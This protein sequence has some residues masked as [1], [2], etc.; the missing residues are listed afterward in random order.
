MTGEQAFPPPARLA[1]SPLV[2]GVP[3]FAKIASASR[4]CRRLNID[5]AP[6]TTKSL[7]RPRQLKPF[8]R[9]DVF[10][11]SPLSLRR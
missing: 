3:L 8:I 7:R 2:V 9:C 10:L 6:Q 1:S 5:C 11:S 4:S